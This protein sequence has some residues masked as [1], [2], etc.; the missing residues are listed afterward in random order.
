METMFTKS[1]SGQIWAE[2]VRK[3]RDL[4]MISQNELAKK[5]RRSTM[6]IS[7]YEEGTIPSPAIIDLIAKA[8]NVDIHELFIPV[9]EKAWPKRKVAL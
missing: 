8:F 7:R 5:V 4:H 1:K 9:E 3:Y 2:N 6:A